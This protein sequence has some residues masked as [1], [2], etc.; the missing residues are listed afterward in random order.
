[1]IQVYKIY[2]VG[3]ASNSYFI[4]KNGYDAI[5]VDPSQPRIAEEA[6]KL[7]L[8]VQHVLLTH[9]HFDHVGGCATLQRAG[10]TIG[11]LEGEERL[12]PQINELAHLFGESAIDPFCAS[13]TVKDG[14]E[15]MLCNLK[16]KVVATPGHTAGSACYCIEDQIFTGD[17]LFAGSVG[18][19]DL[20]T[21]NQTD[22]FCSVKKLYALPGDYI[23][24]PGHGED[25]TLQTEREHNGVV[26]VC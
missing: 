22:V 20:P 3:F 15:F 10:A 26:R 24:R 14:Q 16:I 9:A 17:T 5:A 21:G 6:K 8:H 2:P 4:T 12:F 13:F 25:S 18:R 11:C 19:W 7:G 23:V 1:M